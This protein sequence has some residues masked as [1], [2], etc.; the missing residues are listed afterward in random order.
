[1]YTS[2]FHAVSGLVNRL[3]NRLLKMHYTIEPMITIYN[4]VICNDHNLVESLKLPV[5][6]LSKHFINNLSKIIMNSL[7]FNNDQ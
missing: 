7:Q 3:Q 2:T 4:I 5:G 6:N 1:M